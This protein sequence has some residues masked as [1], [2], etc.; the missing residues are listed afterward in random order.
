MPKAAAIIS[1]IK[2]PRMPEAILTQWAKNLRLVTYLNKLG[3][4][5]DLNEDLSTPRVFFSYSY[6]DS[7]QL[8]PIFRKACVESGVLPIFADE[9]QLGD[10]IMQKLH[11]LILS[12]DMVVV[13]IT[14]SFSPNVSIELSYSQ[15]INKLFF[16]FVRKPQL[17]NDSAAPLTE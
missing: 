9:I 1:I 11:Q 15:V 3:Q 2:A 17:H 10:I 6:R 7:E 13:V 4:V 12:S 14:K 5:S 16:L 8:K